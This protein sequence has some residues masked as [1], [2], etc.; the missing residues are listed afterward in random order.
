METEEGVGNKDNDGH[1]D[2]EDVGN[3]EN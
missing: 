3:G 1:D 2:H